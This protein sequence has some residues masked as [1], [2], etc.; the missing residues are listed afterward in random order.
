MHKQNLS[1]MHNLLTT[2]GVKIKLVQSNK[3][4]LIYFGVDHVCY[5]IMK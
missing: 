2:Y 5:T 3:I 4:Y 1:M